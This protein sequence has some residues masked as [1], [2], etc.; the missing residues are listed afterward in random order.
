[1]KVNDLRDLG[2]DLKNSKMGNILYKGL[3][4]YNRRTISIYMS[5]NKIKCSLGAINFIC[6][7]LEA[8]EK[9]SMNVV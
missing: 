5:E 4:G 1:M 7:W 6:K 2:T 8:A 9:S 3:L